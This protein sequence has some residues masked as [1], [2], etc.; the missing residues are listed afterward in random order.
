MAVFLVDLAPGD[1]LQDL[2]ETQFAS[3]G[4]SGSAPLSTASCAETW[5]TGKTGGF[6]E[7]VVFGNHGNMF[8]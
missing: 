6:R 8:V 7:A 5:K 4:L 3:V 2:A 1:F